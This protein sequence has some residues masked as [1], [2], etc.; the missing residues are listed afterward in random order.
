MIKNRLV[1]M[2]STVVG[3]ATLLVGCGGAPANQ[4]KA[5][6]T[7]NYKGFEEY[8]IIEANGSTVSDAYGKVSKAELEGTGGDT[9]NVLSPDEAPV[10][11]RYT[12][13][14]GTEKAFPSDKIST[15]GLGETRKT[16]FTLEDVNSISDLDSVVWRVEDSKKSA[17]LSGIAN[18]TAT[19][20]KYGLYAV[21]TNPITFTTVD[22]Q[23]IENGG[24]TKSSVT[25]KRKTGRIGKN[26]FF[27]RETYKV[28]KNYDNMREITQ[29]ETTVSGK[30]DEEV[31]YIITYRDE[32]DNEFHFN[33]T[34]DALAPSIELTSDGKALENGGRTTKSVNVKWDGVDVK[35]ATY[36]FNNSAEQEIKWNTTFDE[37]GRY[38][39]NLRDSVDNLRQVEFRIEA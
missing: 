18:D 12:A 6:N 27:Y 25:V 9:F 33:T 4:E 28:G 20:Q 21:A 30:T 34:V 37:P 39:V 22:N 14:D 26:A 11:I 7:Y 36:S 32:M 19:K 10:E 31:T 8:Y 29:D 24:K 2:L 35:S 15:I 23:Q 1:A 3:T 5:L 38:T 16:Y 13:T 17:F